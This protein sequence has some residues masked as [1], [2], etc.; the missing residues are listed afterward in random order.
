MELLCYDNFNSLIRIVILLRQFFKN[1]ILDKIFFMLLKCKTACHSKP[2]IGMIFWPS[3]VP[4]IQRFFLILSHMNS[5]ALIY[6]IFLQDISILRSALANIQQVYLYK[7]VF[8]KKRN[9][10]KI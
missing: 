3:I 10:E 2:N 9:R 1:F 7:T 6:R 4:L 5:E 8:L